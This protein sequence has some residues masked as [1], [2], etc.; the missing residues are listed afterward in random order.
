MLRTRKK[1]ME[2]FNGRMEN[3]TKDIGKMVNNMEREF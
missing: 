2:Y 1:D 3:N